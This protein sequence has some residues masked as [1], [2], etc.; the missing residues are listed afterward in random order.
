MKT[1][2]TTLCCLVLALPLASIATGRD[3]L[4][5]DEIDQIKEAQEPNLRLKLYADFAKLRVDL[6]KNMLGKEK[7]GRSILIHDALEDYSKILDAIDTVADAAAAKKTDIKLG[8][9]AV[10]DVEKQLLPVLKQIQDTHPKDLERYEFALTQAIETTSDSLELAQEDL[11]KRG[12]DVETREEKQKKAVEA[13]MSPVE[14][15][16]QKAADDKKKADADKAAEDDKPKRKPP[17]LMR[18]G[19]KKQQ[20]QQQQQQ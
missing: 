8:L 11:G 7:A 6:V 14:K 18:P 9:S 20:Q 3:F 2:T 4:S 12:K 15:E 1:W 5:A 17:T 13:E 19:E 16:G 10:A